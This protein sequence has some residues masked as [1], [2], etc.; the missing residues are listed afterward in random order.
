[1]SLECSVA[2]VYRRDRNHLSRGF[3]LRYSLKG[4]ACNLVLQYFLSLFNLE[5]LGSLIYVLN[6]LYKPFITSINIYPFY[7]NNQIRYLTPR[8]H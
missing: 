5:G 8:V 3:Y 4:V 6:F 7:N 2:A 1:M